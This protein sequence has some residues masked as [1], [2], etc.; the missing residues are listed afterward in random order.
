M[1]I[2]IVRVGRLLIVGSAIASET[3]A[4]QAQVLVQLIPLGLQGLSNIVCKAGAGF[5]ENVSQDLQVSSEK[6]LQKSAQPSETIL[7]VFQDQVKFTSDMSYALVKLC[8]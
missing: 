8:P 5:G 6:D 7:Q 1:F 3:I 4:L 2:E